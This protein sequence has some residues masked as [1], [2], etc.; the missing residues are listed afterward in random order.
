MTGRQLVGLVLALAFRPATREPGV[1]RNCGNFGTGD[2]K[3]PC[4]TCGMA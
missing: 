4:P 3:N 2:P 1:C